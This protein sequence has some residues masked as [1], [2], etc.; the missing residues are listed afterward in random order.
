MLAKAKSFIYM[1]GI[2]QYWLKKL[3]TFEELQILELRNIVSSPPSTVRTVAQSI[4][5]YVNLQVI[6]VEFH[7]IDEPDNFLIMARGCRLLRRFR[8]HSLKT[9][10][11]IT[12]DQ[13]SRLLR[14]LPKVERLAL[15]VKFLV[16]AS[17][18]QYVAR[19]CPRLEV[20]ELAHTRLFLSLKSLMEAPVFPC[21]AAI[22]LESVWF[23]KPN[24]HMRLS[25]LRRIAREWSRVFPRLR[26]M[27]CP[28]DVYGPEIEF[29]WD[30]SSVRLDGDDDEGDWSPDDNGD[31]PLGDHALDL[32]DYG[33]DY[34]HMRRRL[35]KV[36]GYGIKSTSNVRGSNYMWQTNMEIK[37]FGWPV[38]SMETFLDPGTYSS[39]EAT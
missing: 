30:S 1:T 21:L 3:P 4:S 16:T 2:D 27:P 39:I 15:C 5:C 31:M 17:E 7:R 34:F 36:L 20:L 24:R 32:E 19:S 10:P 26:R 14:A 6:D 28:A 38:C 12:S 23:G 35:W 29:E 13:F 33:S 8:V 25:S 11:G 9:Y 37:T 22:H 18:L